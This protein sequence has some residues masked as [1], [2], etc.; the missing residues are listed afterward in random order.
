VIGYLLAI[1]TTSESGSIALLK[2]QDLIEEVQLHSPDGFA[3]ILFDQIA[4]LLARHGITLADIDL[5]VS[6]SGPGSF[7]GVRIGLT[8]VKGLAAATGRK[9]VAVSNLRALAWFGT[10]ELRATMIAAGRGEVYG[11]VYDSS[12]RLIQPEVV[13]TMEAWVASLPTGD[14]ELISSGFDYFTEPPPS[15]LAAAI[16][17][18]AAMGLSTCPPQE[19]Q[20]V[21]AN[22][23]RRSD[24]E[25]LWKE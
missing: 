11:A 15:A 8:A 18:I 3:H 20:D 10:H 4:G 22:Y 7:T 9:V 1:D 17:K 19:P 14:I 23:V 13:T 6:A 21:D 5:F 2:D 24:A 25:L 16:G 12:L